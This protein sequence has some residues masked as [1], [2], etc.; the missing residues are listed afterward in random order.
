[1]ARKARQAP[2]APSPDQFA[3]NMLEQLA[4][5]IGVSG[6]ASTAP[7]L[8]G[9]LDDC[10]EQLCREAE[11][12]STKATSPGVLDYWM[13]ELAELRRVAALARTPTAGVVAAWESG[14]RS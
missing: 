4:F 2:Q 6:R 12:M 5:R 13:R 3:L 8:A 10:A 7:E 9:A 11:S 14:V 1:M